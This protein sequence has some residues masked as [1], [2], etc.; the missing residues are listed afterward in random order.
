MIGDVP[1]MSCS[2]ICYGVAY[3][4]LSKSPPIPNQQSETLGYLQ[5]GW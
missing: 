5:I 4:R 3:A 1:V 2:P